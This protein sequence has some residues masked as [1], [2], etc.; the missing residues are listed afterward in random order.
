MNSRHHEFWPTV[1]IITAAIMWGLFWIPV[2]GVVDAGVNALWSG[3]L[4]FAAGTVV[5]LPLVVIRWR[6][7]AKSYKTYLL[8]G[9][10]SGLAFALYTLAINMTDVVRAILLFYLT[11]LWSTIIG[12]TV[13]GEKLTVNRLLAL[14]LAAVGLSTVLGLGYKFPLPDNLGDWFALLSGFVWSVA[15]TKLF[16]GDS[17]FIIEKA[18]LFVF[19]AFLSCVVLSWLPLGVDATPPT[20]Q[21]VEDAWLSI[22]ILGIMMLPLAFLTIWPCTLLS[23]ARVGMLYMLDVIV[24]VATAAMFAN[25]TFGTREVI[26]T[27]LILSAAVVEV[28]RA[29]Q[30]YSAKH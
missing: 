18:F 26:G 2:R 19:F 11:P 4:I 30:P 3:I 7:L 13:L 10:F 28:S 27:L 24:G 20:W 12:V 15:S 9:L 25:E 23:P 6:S 17:D 29:A 1:A 21:M 5:L 8:A 16:Q 14:V 22:A